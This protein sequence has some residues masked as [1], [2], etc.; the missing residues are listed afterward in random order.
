MAQTVD[1]ALPQLIRQIEPVEGRVVELPEDERRHLALFMGLSLTR[2]PNFREGIEQ[3]HSQIAQRVLSLEAAKDPEFA[4]AVEKYGIKADAKQWVS[5]RPMVSMA[6]Q[7]AESAMQKSFQFFIPPESV[8]LVT[9]DNP[10]VFSG[11]AVGLREIGP[12]HPGAELVMNLR[13]DL[14]LVCTPKHG[15]PDMSTFKLSPTEARKFNRGVVRGA[16]LRVFSSTESS[17]FDSFV[18]KYAGEERRIIV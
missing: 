17:Q 16:S 7:I 11:G 1:N 2:V 3:F 9:S 12:A 5:L 4:E 10:V 18:K 8:P 14:A 13:S 15:H 6:H